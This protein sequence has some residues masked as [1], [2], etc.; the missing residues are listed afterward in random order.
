MSRRETSMTVWYWQQIGGTL[1]EEF[2]LVPR[3]QGQGRRLVDAVIVLGED[4]QR[5]PIGTKVSLEGRDIVV[6]QAKN[7]RLGMYLMGQTLFSAELTRL[8][9]KPRTV[10]SVALCASGD[11]ILK[12]MLEQYDGCEVVICPPNI[13]NTI[14]R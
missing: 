8:F 4:N 6:V 14:C 5:L 1:I 12:P 2:M 9:H 10:R 7:M 3:K 11:R 13:C